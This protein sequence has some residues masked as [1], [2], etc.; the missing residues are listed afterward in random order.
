MK[1]IVYNLCFLIVLGLVAQAIFVVFSSNTT[2]TAS[3]KVKKIQAENYQLQQNISILE[4]KITAQ[5]AINNL[6]LQADGQDYVD[7]DKREV[8]IAPILANLP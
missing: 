6:S 7:I 3:L 4:D 5:Q 1:K 8:I 2:I